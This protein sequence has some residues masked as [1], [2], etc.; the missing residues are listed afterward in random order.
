[1]YEK[2]IFHVKIPV[3]IKNK[4]LPGGESSFDS[5]KPKILRHW[6]PQIIS[7]LRQKKLIEN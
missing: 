3:F 1:M 5:P 2:C 4:G 7:L 6:S